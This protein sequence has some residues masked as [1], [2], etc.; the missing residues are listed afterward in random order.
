MKELAENEKRYV[1]G[2]NLRPVLVR[3]K[4]LLA[5]ALE[6]LPVAGRRATD[7]LPVCRA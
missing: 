7:T 4:D 2:S 3:N 5:R 6:A 1:A